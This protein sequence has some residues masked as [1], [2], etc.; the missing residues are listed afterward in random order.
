MMARKYSVVVIGLGIVGSASLWRLSYSN[1]DVLGIDSG[2]PRNVLGSSYGASRIFRRAYWE[3]ECYLPLLSLSDRLWFELA[4]SC[5]RRLIYNTGGLFVGPVA[6]AVVCKSAAAARKG[7]IKHVN[8][9]ATEIANSFPQFNV[10]EGMEALYE[11]G[12]YT[13]AADDSKSHMIDLAVGNGVEA[14]FET[15]VTSIVRNARGLSIRLSGGDVV[16]TERVI[17]TTGAAIGAALISD[18]SGLVQPQSVPVYWFKPKSGRESR[19]INNFPAFLYQLPDGRLL[20]GTP[21]VSADEPGI[22]I[23]FHNCQQTPF[24]IEAHVQSVSKSFIEQIS[25]CVQN[26]FPDLNP[27]PY[28]AKKCIYTMSEDGAFILG[29]SA[30]LPGVFYASACSGHGFKFATGLGHVLARAALEGTISDEVAMFSKSRFAI[31]RL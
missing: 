4:S 15:S 17:L 16:C 14:R 30:E 11:E 1:A 24:E 5:D 13:I 8:L 23:G 18:L 10:T 9:S 20:Y 27:I 22:K 7:N 12:A 2:A 28:A 29:E 19:F 26:L 3:G 25:A 21:K 6:S 31:N